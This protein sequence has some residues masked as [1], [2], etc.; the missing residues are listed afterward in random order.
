MSWSWQSPAQNGA[1]QL[2][3][4]CHSDDVEIDGEPVAAVV[5]NNAVHGPRDFAFSSTLIYSGIPDH[6]EGHD[7]IVKSVRVFTPWPDL[8]NSVRGRMKKHA[9]TIVFLAWLLAAPAGLAQVGEEVDI[10]RSNLTRE[11]EAVQEKTL[12]D[13]HSLH[14]TWFRDV[15]SGT[16]PQ[17]VAKFVNEFKLAEENNLQFLAN[18]LAAQADYDDGYQ[19]PKAGEDFRKRCGWPQGSSQL[20]KMNLAKLSQRLRFQFDAVKA[21]NLTI[22]AFEMGNEVDW[23][24][25]NGGEPDGHVTTEQEFM[26]AVR[27]YAHFLKPAAEVILDPRYVP[28]ATYHVDG[29]GTHIYP[30]PDD[31][32][33][34]VTDLIRQDAAILGPDKP[35]WITKWGLPSSKYPNKQGLTRS[36]GIRNFYALLDRLHIPLGPPFYY[37]FSPGG[38]QL[39]DANGELLPEASVVAKPALALAESGRVVARRAQTFRGWGMSLAWEGNDLYGGDRQPAQIKDPSIQNQYMD[40]LFGDPATRLT[41]G[42]TIARY[43][44]AGGD[45]PTHKHMR[46]DAQ[47]E[48]FQSG[49][50]APFDW[51]RDAPQRRMLQEAKNR[52]AI[53]FEAASY[54]PPYWMT[55]SGCSSGAKVGHQDNLRPDM[56]QSFVDYLTTV[57]KHFRDAAGIHFESLEPFNEPD[58][59]WAAGG[60]QEGNGAS[61]SSQ[62]AI[63]PLLAARLKRDGLDTFVSGVDMNNLGAAIGG[64]A[65]LNPAALSALGRLNT[66][67]YHSHPNPGELRGYWSLAQK[68]NKPIWMSELG[69]CFAG[70]DDKSEMWGALFLADSV[71]MDLRDLHSEAWVLWQPDWNVIAFDPKGGAPHPKKQFYV[72]A[73]Y[74]RFIRPGFQIISAGGAYNTLAAYSPASKRLVLVSTNW[75]SPTANDLDLS[76]FA[77]VPSSAVVYRTT[78]DETVNLQEGKIAI[79]S[80]ANLIDQL[81]VRSVTT[82]VID[83]VS[84]RPDL[85]PNAIEGIHEIVSE[86]TKL[87]LNITRNSTDS[88]G[89]IIPYSCGG[90][91]NNMVFNLVDRGAGFYSIHTL[92]GANDLCLAISNDSRSPGDGKTAGGPGNLVQWNCGSG[93]PPPDNELF[94]VVNLG[95]GREQIQVKSSGLCL[96]DPGRGGTIRQ[97]HCDRSNPNQEFTLTE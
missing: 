58:G 68:L 64:V 83:G 30:N 80:K 46:A 9:Y 78:A 20:S 59:G 61:F 14:A 38:S 75:D 53:I 85:P 62:N 67:D 76:G 36:E 87:C 43:D 11:S 16:T 84:P 4:H 2:N 3:L 41:L 60:R 13:I 90:G 44:I 8:L 17:T 54:S 93:T 6:P 72:L 35:F 12:R 50:N 77:G 47:M 33:Q 25:F 86:G 49:P 63:L 56:Y 5:T 81:P 70:Q 95:G 22:D 15:L 31:L 57:V 82:Y 29:Y 23:I 69:C 32:D 74:T 52:G 89:G 28:N 92:N 19:N 1:G 27:G 24:C 40:L 34:S 45:D 65:Q 97:N 10:D 71:R 48:G 39:I 96:E 88:G 51:T 42:F 37:A 55:F 73:Q 26:T 91:F 18:V 7:M 79:S 66:H 94:E 21:A